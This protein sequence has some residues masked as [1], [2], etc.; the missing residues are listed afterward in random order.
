MATTK[1][2]Q[3]IQ[4]SPAKVFAALI[5]AKAVS[6][7]MVPDGMSSEVQHFEPHEGGTFRISLTYTSAQG[8]GKTSAKTDTYHGHFLKLVPGREVVQAMEFETTDPAM[9]GEMAVTFILADQDKGTLVTAEHRNVP[10]GIKPEDNE[11]GW[12]MALQ[13]LAKLVEA[14]VQA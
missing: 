9:Q 14:G 3:H 8:T 13:K 11:T 12:R 5:D 7:W 2:S 10:G 4:A 6:S 1:L